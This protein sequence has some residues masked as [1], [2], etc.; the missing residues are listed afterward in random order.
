MEGQSESFVIKQ[1]N[2]GACRTY[3]VGSE[4][5]KEAA[6]IDPVLGHVD[7]YLKFLED[8]G[9]TLRYVLDTHTHADHISGGVALTE[10]T[11]AE[12]AMHKKTGVR[13]VGRRLTDGD[14]LRMGDVVME[15]IE[16]PGHT[17]DSV[18]VS[19]PGILL[20]GDWL[21]IGGAGRTDLPGG[22]PAE[23]WESLHRVLPGFSDT[24][25]I[26]PGHDYRDLTESTLGVERQSN[27]NL[28]ERTKEDYV[29]WLASMAQPTPDW[30]LK[31]VRANVAG[32]TDPK[33]AGIPEDAACMSVCS[34]VAA[35][36]VPV[37][38]ISS[39]DLRTMIAKGGPTPLVL[40]VRQ[41]EE[42]VGSVGRLSGASFIP[43]GELQQ[44]LSEISDHREGPIVT[45]CRSGNRSITAAAI[46]IEA[47]FQ[48]V[49]S[50]AGGM[51]DWRQKDYSAED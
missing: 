22:D 42:L 44:R 3:F 51:Q 29:A 12:Y 47:G 32:T 50:M 11:E 46:L 4:P 19:L 5:T 15:V 1:L 49:S 18:T 40:D 2:R 37:P 17:K 36:S 27:R 45:V 31:T 20:T 16:T 14:S 33:V 35:P 39:E 48:N 13:A 25:T 26:L 21:F 43:S 10:R 24:E 8:G 34:P 38:E 7:D 30:M 41:P 9:W 23:H 6:L 28:S